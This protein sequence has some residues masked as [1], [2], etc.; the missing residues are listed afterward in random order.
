MNS[1]AEFSIPADA[2]GA[3]LSS[4][5]FVVLF[6]PGIPLMRDVI[7]PEVGRKKYQEISPGAR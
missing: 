5:L 3:G 2:V 7:A 6:V 1:A 4:F